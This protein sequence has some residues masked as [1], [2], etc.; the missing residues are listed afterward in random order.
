[1]IFQNFSKKVCG[2][3]FV[4][5]LAVPAVSAQMTRVPQTKP[6]PTVVKPTSKQYTVAAGNNL[7]CAGFVQTSPVSTAVK[8]VG[9]ENE[10]EQYVYASHQNLFISKGANAGVKVGD[11]FS[12]IRPRGRVSTHWTKKGDLG[13]YVQ[14]VGAVEVINVKSDVSVVRVKA[15]CENILLGDLLEPMEARTSPKF[16][17]R[18]A[19]DHFSDPSGK[20][21]GRI[22]M[23]RDGRE[24]LGQEQI[25]YIDLG[26]D[27]SVKAGD[28]LTIY[29]RLGKGNLDIKNSDDEEVP[30]RR[31]GYESEKYRGGKFSIQAGRKEGETA[32][33]EVVDTKEAKKN[34]PD[35]L[36]KVVGEMV[37]INVKERTA[38]AVITRA[39]QE[40]HTGDMVEV[41]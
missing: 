19:L 38:T 31:G 14:E 20:A 29:R 22:F 35:N 1:M 11:M 28:Y 26:A 30:N 32:S 33:G 10:Q 6:T 5:M 24:M 23:A 12:V 21:S 40:I 39:A 18:P 16:A 36:R 4:G 25:V 7:Y 17:D 9:A 8:I 41:Q 27:N 34:R 13:F 2:L 3:L 37:I 15:T